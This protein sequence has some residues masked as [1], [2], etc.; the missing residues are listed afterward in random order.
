MAL[1][2]AFAR[3]EHPNLRLVLSGRRDEA[4]SRAAA[5]AGVSPRVIYTD[6]ITEEDLPAFYRGA[7][8]VA[9][10]SLYEGFGI[11]AVEAMACGAPLVA[12]D[13]TSL[14]EVL[15]DA[16]LTIDPRDV[17]DL[18][19]G[20]ERVLT[21][22]ALRARLRAAGPRQAARFSWDDIAQTVADAL[23]TI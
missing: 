4:T 2:E 12:S 21:D 10:P 8:T 6:K 1:V 11:P 16:A 17:D 18:T 13:V 3:L 5:R 15:G 14:P 7:A 19:H 20:L 23:A 22:D 9:F